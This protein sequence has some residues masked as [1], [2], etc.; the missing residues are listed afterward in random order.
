MTKTSINDHVENFSKKRRDAKQVFSLRLVEDAKKI[1]QLD[2]H[3]NEFLDKIRQDA[4]N[5][6]L[7]LLKNDSQ[8][9]EREIHEELDLLF[10]RTK[11]DLE[12][13]V[14]LLN[15]LSAFREELKV[16][17]KDDKLSGLDDS[18]IGYA[19][20]LRKTTIEKL[21]TLQLLFKKLR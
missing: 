8:A 1:E 9:F 6:D 21:E 5:H 7:E 20:A 2:S 12:L 10:K 14:R 16:Q 13:Y 4:G 17:L 11:Q 18:E 19:D 3:V 15:A